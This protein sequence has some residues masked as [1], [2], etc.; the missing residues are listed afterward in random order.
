[1]P[2]LTGGPRA[3]LAWGRIFLWTALVILCCSG[4]TI[5]SV[6]G[7]YFQI[8]M[9]SSQYF[10]ITP[11]VKGSVSAHLLGGTGSQQL[12]TRQE[13]GHTV[14]SVRRAP[15]R[16]TDH[17]GRRILSSSVDEKRKFL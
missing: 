15:G 1:M 4:L 17:K 14:I 12:I 6:Q 13:N 10:K 8:E 3:S 2:L 5:G 7:K 11:R 9:L 16:H